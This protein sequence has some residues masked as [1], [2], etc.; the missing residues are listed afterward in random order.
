MIFFLVFRNNL[1]LVSKNYLRFVFSTV[2]SPPVNDTYIPNA[3]YLV[4]QTPQKKSNV[5]AKVT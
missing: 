1:F 5:P 2:F 4:A 3:K